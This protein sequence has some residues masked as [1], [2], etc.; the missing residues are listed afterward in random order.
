MIAQSNSVRP[1]LQSVR[2]GVLALQSLVAKSAFLT[3][4][5]LTTISFVCR[6][7]LPQYISVR[8]G[9]VVR[10][11]SGKWPFLTLSPLRVLVGRST[12]ISIVPHLG[13]FD[14]EALFTKELSY[15][16][17][18]FCWLEEE[19]SNTYD[20]IIEIGANVGLY[21]VFFDALIKNHPDHRLKRV[22]SFE[23]A[24][25][26][27][28][29]FIENLKANDCRHVVPFRA[30]VGDSSG[31]QS[32]FEPRGHLTNGSLVKNFAKLFSDR[33][34]GS[35]VATHHPR[36]LEVFF[37][38]GQKVLLKIDVEGYEP[39]LVI[40]FQELIEKY[41]PDIL[42]EVLP[43]TPEYLSAMPFLR[44]WLPFLLLP[45]RP[46]RRE[47]NPSRQAAP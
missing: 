7:F 32:F 40:A 13:E 36:D 37:G 2:W 3:R 6:N 10:S 4:I 22:I 23:P 47:G 25:E 12:Y 17:D 29:R 44:R 27:F 46:T 21:S 20:M 34:E 30:A 35:I 15:E 26:P 14:Q 16:R 42:I 1:R 45:G 28:T 8:L 24:L 39:Q 11:N 31:F 5:Y 19:A 18:V 43:G 41:R 9:N 33:V 38:P